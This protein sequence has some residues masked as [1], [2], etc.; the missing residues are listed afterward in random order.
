MTILTIWVH[1]RFASDKP[2]KLYV[3][4]DETLE[5]ALKRLTITNI[6][7]NLSKYFKY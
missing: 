2:V 6:F 3:L 4:S 5:S 1:D 7:S